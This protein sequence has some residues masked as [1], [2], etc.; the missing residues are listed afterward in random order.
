MK[1]VIVILSLLFLLTQGTTM[2]DHSHVGWDRIDRGP[3][4][5]GRGYDCSSLTA[6]TKLKLTAEQADR[7][8]ALD[9]KYA[10]EIDPLRE[11]LYSKGQELKAEWLQTEPD[12]GRIEILQ[13]EAVKL[14]ERMR[15]PL[16]AHRA[17]VLKVLTLE[18]RT[19]VSDDGPGRVFYKPA[20][21]GRW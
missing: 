18:Q 1:K 5:Y 15:A 20:S 14:R 10:Q 11:Q 17:E 19:H 4:G 7:L 3:M 6:N 16:A 8:R 9:E 2:A 13:A 12:R 21:L